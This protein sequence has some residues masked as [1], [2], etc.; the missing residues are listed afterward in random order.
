MKKL[1]VLS[2][3]L[4]LASM[5]LMASDITFG[6]DVTY[7]FIADFDKGFAESTTATVD[8]KAAVNE[9]VSSEVSIKH[10]AE[11]MLLD[12]ATIVTD[13]GAAFALTDMGVGLELTAGYFDTGDKEYG[14]V[15]DYE[16]E[17]VIDVKVEK[18]WMLSTVLTVMDMV[19]FKF[20]IDPS[21]PFNGEFIVGAYAEV[22]DISAEF[23]YDMNGQTEAADGK[24]AFD[25]C[26]VMEMGDISLE[27]GAGFMY[28]MFVDDGELAKQWAY[29]I[30]LAVDYTEMVHVSVGVDGNSM[31]AFNAVMPFGSVTPIDWVSLYAGMVLSFAEDA[32]AFQGA[33]IGI[34]IMPGGESE[35]EIY[36]GYLITENNAGKKKAP[37][38]LQD[39]GAYLKVDIDY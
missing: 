6:G 20:A 37:E 9:F 17:H 2:M 3:L 1:L 13:L 32:D 8:V 26:Y 33:D 31:D 34:K 12:K 38:T 11:D 15:S 19:N 36:I 29:G 30:G 23:F 21:M 18:S 22:G 28:D 24:I 35:P 7:G 10:D 5:P 16:N 14:M 25:A 27:A 4:A 39:G